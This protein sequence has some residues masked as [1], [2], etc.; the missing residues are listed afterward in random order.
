MNDIQFMDIFHMFEYFIVFEMNW[1][2]HISQAAILKPLSHFLYIENW[3]QLHVLHI[4]NRPLALA[5]HKGLVLTQSEMLLW[6]ISNFIVAILSMHFTNV[7]ESVLQPVELL[8][9]VTNVTTVLGSLGM[10]TFV[11]ISITFG[12][13][14]CSTITTYV[15]FLP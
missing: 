2:I 5:I 13:K 10:S 1:R 14:S 7:V 3:M 11:L 12:S 4:P 9:A 6:V 8:S 15:R